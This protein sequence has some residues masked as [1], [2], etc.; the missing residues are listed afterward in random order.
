MSGY[1]EVQRHNNHTNGFRWITKRKRK[2]KKENKTKQYYFYYT[3]IMLLHIPP[4]LRN[5][6]KSKRKRDCCDFFRK[7]KTGGT[8][9][10]PSSF[11]EISH[12]GCFLSSD[13]WYS[14]LFQRGI[15]LLWVGEA[16][17]IGEM[18]PTYLYNCSFS[19]SC[20]AF[21]IAVKSSLVCIQQDE[22]GYLVLCTTPE[23]CSIKDQN[24]MANGVVYKRI[25]RPHCLAAVA[26]F[27]AS[28]S[29]SSVIN[30]SSSN[31]SASLIVLSAAVGEYA[32]ARA[33]PFMAAPLGTE[34]YSGS[35]GLRAVSASA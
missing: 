24:A 7:G 9:R 14:S 25:H 33:E 28:S 35:V 5:P 16:L 10:A 4:S 13:Q 32:C 23:P 18:R 2:K 15:S 27:L 6:R 1:A 22:V 29:S 17:K 30:P 19:L 12:H 21:Q 34:V 31:S 8:C 20:L 3:H 26:S 11:G